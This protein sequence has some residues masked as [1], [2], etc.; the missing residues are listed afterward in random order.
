MVTVKRTRKQPAGADPDAAPP[1]SVDSSV[2]PHAEAVPVLD[3]R[4]RRGKDKRPVN[5][6]AGERLR[7]RE[8]LR[9]L[10]RVGYYDAALSGAFT[11]NDLALL[12]RSKASKG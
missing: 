9:S 8:R 12:R 11:R 6:A 2:Q 4:R 5:L 7:G 3:Q 10:D 1:A